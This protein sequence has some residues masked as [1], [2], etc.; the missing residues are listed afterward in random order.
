[1]LMTGMRRAV[2]MGAMQSGAS[3][4]I[5]L[6]SIKITSVYL[7][8]VGLG[9]VGLF[10]YFISLTQGAVA[11]GANT[12]VVRRVT[13]LADDPQRKRLMLSSIARL[14]LTAGLPIALVIALASSLVA[15]RLLHDGD[16]F[17][18]VVC[19]GAVYVFGLLGSVLTGCAIGS[20]DYTAT[21]LI[22]I[23][24]GFMSFLLMASL[25]IWFGVPGGLYAAS[26][27]PLITFGV[28]HLVG[29][30]RAWWPDQLLAHG[31]SLP[32]AR[33]AMAFVPL[34]LVTTIAMPLVQ[35]LI[36]DSV[37]E[38]SGLA[39]LGLLQGVNRISDIV[40]GLA[41]GLFVMYYLPRFTEIKT[42]G[43][44]KRE[45]ALGVML[46]LPAM[47]AINVS[48]YLLRDLILEA[49]FTPAF[50]HMRDLFAWQMA[51]NV[52]KMLGWLFGTILLA[53]LNPAALVGLELG[54]LVAW[55]GIAEVLVSRYGVH[56]APIAFCATYVLYSL[57]TLALT[58][59]VIRR[60][61]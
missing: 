5:G 50:A 19:F 58:W 17:G 59:R 15:S 45:L 41:S 1:M 16:L 14:V 56:G 6:V 48:L 18:P 13:E 53:K 43:E 27:M 60:M 30:R 46:I 57:V 23:G 12:G 2:A 33:T 8:P 40:I 32:E 47:A 10:S 29:R 25:S 61:P 3:M 22:N 37:V 42:A 35:I 38:V 20:K 51:G 39:D 36:R 52:F 44:M 49:L 4:V 28:I 21:T 55:W 11:A 54:A 24:G 31:F 9:L 26:L 7:G 34:A